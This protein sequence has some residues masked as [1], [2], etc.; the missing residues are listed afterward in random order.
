MADLVLCIDSSSRDVDGDTNHFDIA[1][2]RHNS[3]IQVTC[4][5]LLPSTTERCEYRLCVP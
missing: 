1:L 2:N 4:L 3:T 5:I